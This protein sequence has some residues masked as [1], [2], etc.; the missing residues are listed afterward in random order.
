MPVSR[1]I[2]SKGNQLAY[3][4]DATA[5]ALNALEADPGYALGM[6]SNTVITS[7]ARAR[8]GQF[9]R[10]DST[11]AAFSVYLPEITPNDVG[12]TV[13]YVNV[14]SIPKSVTLIPFNAT[15]DGATKRTAATPYEFLIIIAATTNKW[16]VHA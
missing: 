9:L 5:R 16:I 2:G 10:A 3:A 11:R 14:A 1:V 13:T 8:F 12:R 15:I 6:P 7:N 4:Q